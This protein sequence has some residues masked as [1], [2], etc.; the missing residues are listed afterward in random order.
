MLKV[1][2]FAIDRLVKPGKVFEFVKFDF[3]HTLVQR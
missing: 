1:F 2:E 3:V